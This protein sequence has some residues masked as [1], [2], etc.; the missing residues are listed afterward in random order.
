MCIFAVS[1]NHP[2][3]SV[4]NPIAISILFGL[5][6]STAIGAGDK[7]VAACGLHSHNTFPVATGTVVGHD[8]PPNLL[9]LSNKSLYLLT[10][11]SR[12][13]AFVVSIRPEKLKK[14]IVHSVFRALLEPFELTAREPIDYLVKRQ[15]HHPLS[16]I[17]N[18]QSDPARSVM[19]ESPRTGPASLIASS[20]YLPAQYI[21]HLHPHG[22]PGCA[23]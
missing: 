4:A 6:G 21:M 8:N 3:T 15:S 2:V 13:I 19:N 9:T 18:K 5:P 22:V 20:D 23:L 12:R 10:Y 11:R 1:W 7:L 16:A 14:L 17:P